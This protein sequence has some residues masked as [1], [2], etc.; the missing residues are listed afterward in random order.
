M[1]FLRQKGKIKK[2]NIYYARIVFFIIFD[3]P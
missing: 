3:F 2:Q 1:F